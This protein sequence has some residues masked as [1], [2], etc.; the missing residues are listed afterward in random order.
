MAITTVRDIINKAML[1]VNILAAGATPTAEEAQDALDMLNC[2]ISE[3]SID[4]NMTLARTQ[5][6]S[7]ISANTS[8]ISIGANQTWNT[9]KPNSIVSGFIRDGNSDY[10][11]TVINRKEYDNITDKTTTGRPNRLF[12]DPGTTQ[13]ANQTGT[14]YLY[15]VSDASYTFYITSDKGLTE[16]SSLTSNVTFPAFYKKALIYNL[17]LELCAEYGK[18]IPPMVASAAQESKSLI[19]SLN[20]RQKV[21]PKSLGLPGSINFDSYGDCNE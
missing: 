19:A 18:Q 16:F 6:S 9:E 10:D 12:Y 1:R 17:A 8:N 11:V 7:N 5:E 15:P 21:I 20:A 4:N 14:I 13:Q 3:W 2:I